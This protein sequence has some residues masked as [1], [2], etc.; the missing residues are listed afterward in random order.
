VEAFVRRAFAPGR[1]PWIE[2]FVEL[3]LTFNQVRALMV[4]EHHGASMPIGQIA[5]LLGLSLPSA[6]RNVDRLVKLGLVDRH[7]QPDDRRV[8]LVGLTAEGRALLDLKAE[9]HR[10]TARDY[11]GRLTEDERAALVAVLG[12]LGDEEH[13]AVRPATG[14]G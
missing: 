10:A 14:C 1:D 12:P 7:E 13:P 3:D 11:L 6:G 2:S 9:G 8:K 5:G 4:L